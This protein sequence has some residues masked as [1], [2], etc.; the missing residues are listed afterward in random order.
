[1]W[2]AVLLRDY[3]GDYLQEYVDERSWIFD[4]YKVDLVYGCSDRNY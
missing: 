1:M 3:R 2:L 4:S